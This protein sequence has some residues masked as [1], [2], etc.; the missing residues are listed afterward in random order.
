MNSPDRQIKLLG[1]NEL[2]EGWGF[3]KS[4]IILDRYDKISSNQRS[5]FDA[6]DEGK[7]MYR[8]YHE[9]K[10]RHADGDEFTVIAHRG[11]SAYYPENTLAAFQ[12]A[13][14]LQADMIELDVQQTSDGNVVVFHDERVARCT[15]GR[16]RLTDYTLA[17]LKKLDA[18]KWFSEDFRGERIPTLEETLELT[19]GKIA[20]NIEI[21]TEAVSDVVLGGIEEKCIKAVY[22]AGVQKHVVFS[23][24]DPRALLHLRQID[25]T[26]STSVLYH[27]RYHQGKTP[28]QTLTMLGA[29][30]FNCSLRELSRKRLEN[31]LSH[32]IPFNVYTVNDEA[33][34]LRLFVWQAGG[35][36][37]NYPD[38][39][40][41]ARDAFRLRGRKDERSI[42]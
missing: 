18:G 37:T 8:P 23:S 42:P 12:G 7:N 19:S 39:L 27:R 34:M 33:S 26:V 38:I 30:A 29:N 6:M 10:Y 31:I 36:F 1:R 17:G 22:Q 25:N 11:A 13:I 3:E 24:F 9:F 16:G 28:S 5:T 41:K 35:I 20:L 21:K 14:D 2:G 40:R 32:G 4:R 15:D